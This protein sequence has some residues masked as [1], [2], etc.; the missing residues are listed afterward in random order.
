MDF[1]AT[2]L[3]LMQQLM[4]IMDEKTLVKVASFFKKEVPA[5]GEEED[6][7]TDAEVTELEQRRARYLSGESKPQSVE[8]AMR[9]VRKVPK[10]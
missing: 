6:D 8:E 9:L 4:G 10:R 2:K 1:A 5:V 7:L 3:Q